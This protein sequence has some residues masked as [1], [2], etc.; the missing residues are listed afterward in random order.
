M[1]LLNLKGTFKRNLVDHLHSVSSHFKENDNLQLAL[2]IDSNIK[3]IA[4]D[5]LISSNYAP[6]LNK[7]CETLVLTPLLYHIVPVTAGAQ[8]LT[9]F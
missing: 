5:L 3:F 7:S 8:L 4:H 9:E 2:K 1:V 6:K